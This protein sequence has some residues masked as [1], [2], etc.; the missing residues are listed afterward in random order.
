MLTQEKIRVGVLRGGPSPEY[1]V[2]LESGAV[3]LAHLESDRYDSLDILIDK[4]GK[5]FVRGIEDAPHKILGKVDAVIN[6]LHGQYGESGGVQEILEAHRVPFSGSR[7]LAS[8]LSLN[9]ALAKRALVK[10]GLQTPQYRVVTRAEAEESLNDFALSLFRSFPQ[11]SMVKPLCGGS[12]LGVSKVS[13]PE[14]LA[15]ALE[16]AFGEDDALLV[17]EYIDGKEV[18]CGVI[19]NFRNEPLYALL[20]VEV[21]LPEG[22]PFLEHHA[23]R[24]GRFIN[25]CPTNL[26]EELK[27]E[28]QGLAR[29][30]HELL[31]LRHYSSSD[32]ILNPTRGLY[33]LETDSLPTLGRS[34]SFLSSLQA[35]GCPIPHFLH[36]LVTLALDEK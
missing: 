3:A 34:S 26:S 13:T 1:A 30:A 17:E 15:Y 28:L 32:F 23:R 20:P 9:K 14:D 7:R 21:K 18:T 5:W 29:R 36:H 31:G 24:E 4:T 11:P 16:L 12:S 22:A 6:A 19:E 27:G 8:A 10:A 35:I 33:F 2:S 25:L